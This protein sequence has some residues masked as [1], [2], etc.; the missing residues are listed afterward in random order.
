MSGENLK[1]HIHAPMKDINMRNHMDL[2][3]ISLGGMLVLLVK[4]SIFR[5]TSCPTTS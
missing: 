3:S 2:S 5:E 4:L 1:R